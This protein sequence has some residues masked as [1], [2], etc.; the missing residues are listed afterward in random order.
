M[1]AERCF[2]IAIVGGAV[3]FIGLLTFSLRTFAAGAIVAIIFM[4]LGHLAWAREERGF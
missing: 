4:V 2:W 3:I 1:S